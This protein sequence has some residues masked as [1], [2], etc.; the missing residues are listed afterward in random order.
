MASASLTNNWPAAHTPSRGLLYQTDER[1]HRLLVPL[2]SRLID[3]SSFLL[4]PNRITLQNIEQDNPR[5]RVVGAISS[6]CQ[7]AGHWYLHMLTTKCLDDAL[8]RKDDQR[9][10]Q[11]GIPDLIR[12]LD[13]PFFLSTH[14]LFSLSVLIEL[15]FAIGI[16]RYTLSD[17]IRIAH[18]NTQITFCLVFCSP[19][20]PL[21][22]ILSIVCIF[23][24]PFHVLIICSFRY[25]DWRY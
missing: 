4:K 24:F 8:I 1:H 10:S 17:F 11:T 9:E 13:S 5:N 19:L 23:C 21:L 25:R 6:H 12:R 14:F 7:I 3:K 22:F 20:I 18:V 16:L 2:P 15:V